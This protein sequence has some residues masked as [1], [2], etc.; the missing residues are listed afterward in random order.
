MPELTEQEIT[1]IIDTDLE[2]HTG[3]EPVEVLTDA[4]ELDQLT[5]DLDSLYL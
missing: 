1:N 4:D 3:E 2:N 5:A